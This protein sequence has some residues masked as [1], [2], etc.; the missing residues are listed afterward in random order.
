MASKNN[1]S[2]NNDGLDSSTNTTT[3]NP[4]PKLGNGPKVN[5]Y[6]PILRAPREKKVAEVPKEIINYGDDRDVD[7]VIPQRQEEEEV[8]KPVT[9]NANINNNNNIAIDL[10]PK[11]ST[12]TPLAT[13]EDPVKVSVKKEVTEAQAPNNVSVTEVSQKDHQLLKHTGA[14]RSR[15]YSSNNNG[16]L[17]TTTLKPSSS[18]VNSSKN[19]NKALPEN[20]TRRDLVVLSNDQTSVKIDDAFAKSVSSS[21]P[22]CDFDLYRKKMDIWVLP[23]KRKR[24]TKHLKNY[25]FPSEVDGG[26]NGNNNNNNKIQLNNKLIQYRISLLESAIRASCAILGKL[27]TDSDLPTIGQYFVSNSTNTLSPVSDPVKISEL[28]IKQWFADNIIDRSLWMAIISDPRQSVGGLKR[29]AVIVYLATICHFMHNHQR[30]SIT[31]T[32]FDITSNQLFNL[33]ITSETEGG[34]EDFYAKHS[35]VHGTTTTTATRRGRDVRQYQRD[36]SDLCINLN[37]CNNSFSGEDYDGDDLE[38]SKANMDNYSRLS[39]LELCTHTEKYSTCVNCLRYHENVLLDANYY[40]SMNLKHT[41]ESEEYSSNLINKGSTSLIEDLFCVIEK[42]ISYQKFTQVSLSITKQTDYWNFGIKDDK[43]EDDGCVV[44]DGYDNNDAVIDHSELLSVSP[45]R[46]IAPRNKLFEQFDLSKYVLHKRRDDFP[47]VNLKDQVNNSKPVADIYLDSKS[48]FAHGNTSTFSS[49]ATSAQNNNN[50][51]TEMKLIDCLPPFFK[52]YIENL[53]SMTTLINGFNKPLSPPLPQSQPI[54]NNSTLVEHLCVPGVHEHNKYCVFQKDDY[55]N[56]SEQLPQTPSHYLAVD[57]FGSNNVS[58]QAAVGKTLIQGGFNDYGSSLH[59]TRRLYTA[60]GGDAAATLLHNQHEIINSGNGNSSV[61]AINSNINQNSHQQ[62]QQSQHQN[63]HKQQQ[64]KQTTVPVVKKNTG[65]QQSQQQQQTQR[66]PFYRR[67][68]EVA[69]LNIADLINKKKRKL[70]AITPSPSAAAV[71]PDSSVPTKDQMEVDNTSS[72]NNNNGIVEYFQ[73]GGESTNKKPKLFDNMQVMIPGD[74]TTSEAIVMHIPFYSPDINHN[75]VSL[76]SINANTLMEMEGRTAMNGGSTPNKLV[77]YR[78]QVPTSGIN[79]LSHDDDENDF[80]S[81]SGYIIPDDSNG[82]GGGGGLTEDG[83]VDGNASSNGET[84][85]RLLLPP[86]M[87]QYFPQYATIVGNNNVIGGDS[88]YLINN[89]NTDSNHLLTLLHA[90]S[91]GDNT[92]ATVNSDSVGLFLPSTSFLFDHHEDGSGSSGYDMYGGNNTAGQEGVDSPSPLSSDTKGTIKKKRVYKKRKEVTAT[93]ADTTATPKKPR[94]R[95]RKNTDTTP[96]DSY[97]NRATPVNEELEQENGNS[98][99]V[100]KR[101][102]RLKKQE[103]K[104]DGEGDGDNK[105]PRRQRKETKPDAT[106][107]ATDATSTTT[108]AT[109]KKITRTRQ[110]KDPKK[111]EPSAD[112]GTPTT[113][114]KLAKDLL[115]CEYCGINYKGAVRHGECSLCKVNCGSRITPIRKPF[116][117]EGSD[118][119]TIEADNTMV[120]AINNSTNNNNNATVATRKPEFSKTAHELFCDVTS[121]EFEAFLKYII[122][123]I[124]DENFGKVTDFIK[125]YDRIKNVQIE[126]CYG[127]RATS[128]MIC[129]DCI[130]EKKLNPNN[131]FIGVMKVDKDK[132]EYMYKVRIQYICSYMCLALLRARKNSVLKNGTPDQ[133]FQEFEECYKNNKFVD[134]PDDPN[135]ALNK[136]NTTT[137]TGADSDVTYVGSNIISAEAKK[138]F[139]F[140]RVK[141]EKKEDGDS[142]VSDE[143]DYDDDDDDRFYDFNEEEPEGEPGS[144]SAAANIPAHKDYFHIDHFVLPAIIR[145]V[146][147]RHIRNLCRQYKKIEAAAV[148]EAEAV[149][150]SGVNNN[151]NNGDVMDCDP[152]C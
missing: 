113:N 19:Q 52:K 114:N 67:S 116:L 133:I 84:Q 93:T 48:S 111:Q 12:T 145:R 18:S 99:A 32:S 22:P 85:Q 10:V 79:G 46:L 69:K 109:N 29:F 86:Q 54:A 126:S 25:N 141:K 82:G 76:T 115:N 125:K 55:F 110:K 17:E 4:L 112:P 64:Q 24:L 107:A 7:V 73:Q 81:S 20:V 104:L 92:T 139:D 100:K 78:P 128:N 53:H 95:K 105:K 58:E 149:T 26:E 60:I 143:E 102:P 49:D 74:H 101:S 131:I 8:T 129:C 98:G 34:H 89:E 108:N 136:S 57:F 71:A 123:G 132:H 148:A 135:N 83:G 106:A 130:L 87:Q 13:K 142:D 45:K 118:G 77:F 37:G 62:Q 119:I 75:A 152:T 30:A 41:D 23:S 94:G 39:E 21:K 66:P 127:C 124:S 2:N 59:G 33:C 122:P 15:R 14:N 150:A 31:G 72:N 40:S 56:N 63:H 120:D 91:G 38:L 42:V 51:N 96:D 80:L 35:H 117:V 16:R 146:N 61:K 11:S 68:T 90:E 43:E 3:T 6:V 138:R 1:N 44:H 134:D 121:K 151:N 144:T 9:I 47:I 70:S 65:A 36:L 5:R 28:V 147:K 88:E 27:F 97:S 137:T 50:N 140:S 103:K